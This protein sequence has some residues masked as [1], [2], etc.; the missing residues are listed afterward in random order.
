MLGSDYP[1]AIMDPDPVGRLVALA[2]D[3]S[4]A[5]DTNAVA[6]NGPMPG[7]VGT[8]KHLLVLFTQRHQ[9]F[10]DVIDVV[11]KT[12]NP[13]ELLQHAFGDYPGQLVLSLGDFRFNAL[14]QESVAFGQSNSELIK[15]APECI[16]LHDAYLHKLR[17]HSMQSQA[18]LLLLALDGNGADVKLLGGYPDR[19]GIAGVGLV[20]KHKGADLYGR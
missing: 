17:T 6:V 3:R 13:G 2:P 9:P 14:Q 16:S 11:L 4:V 10:V 8:D 20:T 19:L 1:F 15:Q 5:V 7:I 12:I 18:S